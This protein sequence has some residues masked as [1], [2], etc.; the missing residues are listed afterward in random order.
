MR[1]I[2]LLFTA[3]SFTFGADVKT[4]DSK[5]DDQWS[6]V[7]DLKSG[8]DIRVY[9]KGSAQPILA[10]AGDATDEKL[11]V[12]LKNQETAIDKKDIE[13][14]EA[15]PAAGKRAKVESK[16]T[17]NDPTSQPVDGVRP[18]NY[19]KPGSTYSSGVSMGS[20]PDFETIYQRRA[21]VK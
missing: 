10:K 1:A 3:L 8:T 12:V 18:E 4:A 14:I 17:M 19:P 21:G 20:K 6:K 15:R 13:R 16:A 11:I 7:K 2:I 5:T 9:K